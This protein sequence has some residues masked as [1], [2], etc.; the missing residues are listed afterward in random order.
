MSSNTSTIQDEDGDY[1]DW[2][3]LFNITDDPINLLDYGLSDDPAEPLKWTFPDITIPAKDFLLI[4]ASDKN[5][6]TVVNHWE[7][8]IDWGDEWAYLPVS[9]EISSDWKTLGFD[10]SGWN[11]GATG[12]GYGDGDDSTEIEPALTLYLRKSFIADD[13]SNI[14]KILLHVDYDDAFAAYINGQEIARANIGQTGVPPAYDQ[15][16]DEPR[17][18][19]MYQ[20]NDPGKYEVQSFQSIIQQDENLLAVEV[21]NYGI[22]SSD[23]TII[24]FLSLGMLE[25]PSPSNGGNP[26]LNLPLHELHTNFKIKSSG[27]TLLLSDPQGV[28]LDILETDSIPADISR[29]RKPDGAADWYYFEEPTP[30]DSNYTD[31]YQQFAP[32][33]QCNINSGFYSTIVAVVLSTEQ[34]DADIYYTLDG[35][36]PDQSSTK[37]TGLIEITETKVLR[38][39]S[40]K[41]GCL[42]GPVMTKTFFIDE[43]I[44]LPVVSLSTN[45]ENLWDEDNGIYVMG[46]NADPEYPY[47]G[48]NFWQDWERPAHVEFFENDGSPGFDCGCGIKIFGGWSRGFPQKSLSVFFRGEYGLSTLKYQLFPDIP[49]SSFESFI[50]RN[51]GNDWESTMMRDGMMQS[52]V[53][54]TGIDVQAYRPAVLFLNGEY[55]GIHNLREKLSEHYIASHH[56]VDPDNIDMLENDRQVIHGDADHYNLLM[57]YI[58]THDMT[59][60]ESYSYINTMMD[61]EEYLD[62][63]IAEIYFDNTDWPGNNLKFWRPKTQWGKWRWLLYDTDFGFSLYDA[64]GY[65]HNTLEFATEE[66]GPEWPNPPWSTLLFRKLLENNQF[67]NDFINRFADHL[68]ITF[69]G[70]RVLEKINQIKNIIDQEI[71]RHLNRWQRQYDEWNSNIERLN[72]FA[73]NRVV[74]MRSFLM[75]K[76]NLTGMG[77]LKLNVSDSLAGKIKINSQIVDAFPWKGHY[78][79]DIPISLK[80]LP[81]YGYHF[82]NWTGSIESDS[83]TLYLY[84]SEVIDLQANFEPASQTNNIVIN[85]IN[86]NSADDFDA[87]DWIE[88]YNNSDNTID[89]SEWVFKDSEDD[90]QFV[91]PANTLL[92]PDSFIV[93]VKDNSKFTSCFP[94]VNNYTGDFDF[95]LSGGGELIRLYNNEGILID[96]VIYDDKTPWPEQ[97]DGQGA[98]LE[99]I[100]PDSDNTLPQNWQASPGHGSPGKVNDAYNSLPSEEPAD[101]PHKF[102]LHRNY[103]NPF[104]PSTRIDFELPQK[105]KVSLKIYDINGKIVAILMNKYLNYGKHSIIWRPDNKIASGVYFYQIKAAKHITQTRRMLLIR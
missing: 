18:A 42:P 62:Y 20:G 4:F 78:F 54:Q 25:E 31:G 81:N 72:T 52:L 82:T 58:D 71:S 83:T 41:D 21:H 57:D 1:P 65:Q 87:E 10:D 5:R 59:S 13:L 24:P 12:I 88:F 3:E 47:F 26:L 97:A 43:N 86:Y 90:H 48:A 56:N 44:T 39:G 9:S 51:S 27:E 60:D 103:P 96:S 35:S 67:K 2:I 32:P 80:A 70:N 53:S 92:L 63:M 79:L 94:D 105:G 46:P 49:I 6:K 85:E 15:W 77:M 36:Q 45:P 8:V 104:N 99:L 75:T 73:Y 11:T 91:F 16:A 17:E 14:V 38:A 30:G 68:N 40:Y 29:G 100:N 89:L 64:N 50:L 7:T 28:I 23:M 22:N 84:I 95:G 34:G 37:Y 33:V 98:T 55:W 101:I 76:F 74:Y 19:E 66:Y 93:L 102:I 61:I 69:E